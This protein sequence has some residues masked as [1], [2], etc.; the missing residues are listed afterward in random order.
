MEALFV[1]LLVALAASSVWNQRLRKRLR[2]AEQRFICQDSEKDDSTSPTS[3]AN[4]SNPTLQTII[5]NIPGGITVFDGDLQMIACNREMLELLDLPSEAFKNTLPTF[6][7]LIRFHATR[8]EHG[9]GDPEEVVAAIMELERISKPHTMERVRS[10]GTVLEI[11]GAPLPDGGFVTIYTDVSE[12]R[13]TAEAFRFQAHYLRSIVEHMPQGISVFDENLQLRCWN[14]TLAEVLELPPESLYDGVLF[15][16]LLM[17]PARRGEYGPG[18]PHEQVAARRA[19]ALKFEGHRFERTRPNGRTHLV[20]GKPMLLD[21]KVVGFITS[22]TD[23]TDRKVSEEALQSKNALLQ[24]LVDNMP[25]G[26]TVFDADLHM[27]LYNDEVLH[28]LDFPADVAATHPHFSEVIRLNA[29][30]GEYGEVEIESKVAEM[31]EL[32]K[33]PQKH[34]VERIRPDGRA[35]EIRGAPIPEGGFVTVYTDVTERRQ[36]A[37]ALHRRSAYLQAVLDQLPQGVSVFDEHLRLKHWND[38][39]F[40]VL[41]LPREAIFENAQFEDLIRIPAERGEYG[42]GDVEEQ[43]RQRRELAERFEPHR[44]VRARPNGRSHLVE[45]QPMMVDGTLAGFITTYTDITERMQ[46]EQE[47]RTRNQI[48]RTLIDNIPGGVTLFDAQFRLVA[49]NDEYRRLLDFPDHL[50]EGTPTLERFFRFNAERG[51]YGECDPQKKVEELL[52]RARSQQPHVFER[53]RPDGTVLQIR[54][55]PLPDGGF[56]TIY[57]DVTEQKAAAEAIEKLAHQ[58][59]LTGLANRYTLEARLDQSIVDARRHGRKL[60]LVFI[61]MDNFKAINDSLGHSVGDD[62]LVKIADRLSACTR[63]NDIVARPGGDEFV[64]V[65]TDLKMVT[66]VAAIASDILDHLSKP[67]LLGS[68][69]VVPSASLGISIYPDDGED[70]IALMKNADIAMYSA[71]TD[72]RNRFRFFDA[73]MTEAASERLRMEGALRQALDQNELVL[74]Y[75][76]KVSA[77]NR[78]IVGYEALVR[79]RSKDGL[80]IPPQRFIPLAEETGLIV[81]IGKWVL[82]TACEDLQAWRNAGIENGISIAVNLS[83]RQLRDQRFIDDVREILAETGIPPDLLELEVTESVAMENPEET[84]SVLRA[85]KE[86]GVALSIDDFGTGYSSLSYLKLLP[87]DSLKLDRTF[88]KDIELDPNDAAICDATIGLAHSLGLKVVAEGVETPEQVGYLSR[89]QCDYMQGYYFS[90]PL[91]E[92]Q[93]VTFNLNYTSTVFDFSI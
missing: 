73:A 15:D 40:E 63:S 78:Q 47:L 23:I 26:V 44:F 87:I 21:G 16:E 43:V 65:I 24:I 69:E 53:T 86:L 93:V 72:G 28:L 59:S 85:L 31:L 66:S 50:F 52:A 89:L 57:S 38:K 13:K 82:R 4:H 10:D 11:R 1:I 18:D 68:D 19:L 51:E 6:E 76:P 41:D 37:D 60:A 3:G 58:D 46:A 5:D 61:D 56:V 2:T 45:G 7:E 79:W 42:P 8:G 35:V 49:C 32:A 34:V 62:F 90:R 48:F 33:N 20:E 77:S 74:H 64:V 71:K 75:Q 39:L 30:R 88:V 80:L 29:S 67:L 25:G 55:L 83:A 91:P 27:A 14:S 81:P 54:G 84:V 22:Y 92:S 17:Y 36:M 12:S 9:K 70:R